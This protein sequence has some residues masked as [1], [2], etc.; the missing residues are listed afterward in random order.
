MGIQPLEEYHHE[1]F[2]RARDDHLLR[3]ITRI[4]NQSGDAKEAHIFAGE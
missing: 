3:E 2:Q 1:G 4:E